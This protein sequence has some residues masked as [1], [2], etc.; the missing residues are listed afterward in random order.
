MARASGFEFTVADLL[1]HQTPAELA[2]VCV[3]TQSSSTANDND[4]TELGNIPLTP[5]QRW[6]F[7]SSFVHASHWNQAISLRMKGS[8]SIDVLQLQKALIAVSAHHDVLRSRYAEDEHGW[9]QYIVAP[10][11]GAPPLTF[12]DAAHTDDLP[13]ALT[14]VQGTLNL[15]KG[16][17]WCAAV[18]RVAGEGD[19]VVL[20]FHHL[21]IDAVSWRILEEDMA[22]AYGGYK[23]PAK[24]TS[25]ASWAHQLDRHLVAQPQW[26]ESS[27]R[28]GWVDTVIAPEDRID[29]RQ[30]SIE[31]CVASEQ[32]SALLTSA[33]TAFRTRPQEL[34][35]VA[36]LI[37]YYQCSGEKELS[38]LLC[39]LQPC[40]QLCLE[41]ECM[42]HWRN[43]S[44][45][46]LLVPSASSPC[47]RSMVCHREGHIILCNAF[48]AHGN[49]VDNRYIYIS[50]QP[51]DKGR[52]RSAMLQSNVQ[53]P[54]ER[55]WA[56]VSYVVPI[57]L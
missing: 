4:R 19:R 42:Q 25:F 49:T 44:R 15:T 32:T 54:L 22:L 18:V 56:E 29:A 50:Q 53:K 10:E 6:F 34:M 16:P 39:R 8:S 2:L 20:V 48:N 43:R 13:A 41:S 45:P 30:R 7:C 14:Q 37:A 36:L 5:I 27:R 47:V 57:F 12:I 26:G 31:I 1:Q 3:P 9:V 23:L 21:V 51:C 35:L 24:T 55:Q 11:E 33:N 28:M 38:V 17:I 40:T 52:G 46:P